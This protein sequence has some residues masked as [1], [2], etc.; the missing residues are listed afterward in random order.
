MDSSEWAIAEGGEGELGEGAEL[1][2][3]GGVKMN[4]SCDCCNEVLGNAMLI[5]LSRMQLEQRR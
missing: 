5:S 2:H 1:I 3:R 4:R